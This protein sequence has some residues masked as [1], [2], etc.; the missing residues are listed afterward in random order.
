[1]IKDFSS[2]RNS[3]FVLTSR[4]LSSRTNL[5]IP[6]RISMFSLESILFVGVFSFECLSVV[7][8][9]IK[10]SGHTRTSSNE[11]IEIIL[12]PEGK[13]IWS[14]R[15]GKLVS[16]SDRDFIRMRTSKTR[17]SLNTSNQEAS[18]RWQQCSQC[19]LFFAPPIDQHQC[20]EECIGLFLGPQRARLILQE[21][22]AGWC[23]NTLLIVL[24]EVIFRRRPS[25]RSLIAF[26]YASRVDLSL[27]W[28]D[29]SSRRSSSKRSCSTRI[30]EQRSAV[31]PPHRSCLATDISRRQSTG[32]QQDHS[33]SIGWSADDRTSNDSER[34][35]RGSRSSY[36]E[37]GVKSFSDLVE[38]IETFILEQWFPVSRAALKNVVWS[39]SVWNIN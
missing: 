2:K 1:M 24:C 38:E 6:S 9:E 3:N 20:A 34:F 26:I 39:P 32:S 23:W 28:D 16:L 10:S 12:T 22:K 18:F 19:S 31:I 21:H 17:S 27:G 4:F 7:L 8:R 13:C 15:R 35:D 36:T 37:V 5:Y 30:E 29:A 33:W 25:E 11:P 14:K